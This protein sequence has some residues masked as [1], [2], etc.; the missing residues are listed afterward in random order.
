MLN[1]RK[2]SKISSNCSFILSDL[3]EVADEWQNELD[4]I[5]GNEPE[6]TSQTD[7]RQERVDRLTYAIGIITE[8]NEKFKQWIN[9]F[10]NINPNSNNA[11]ENYDNLK[12]DLSEI[13]DDYVSAQSN[14]NGIAQYINKLKKV[15]SSM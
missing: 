4:D 13:I 14:K 10:D 9:S 12:Y 1:I 11:E 6:Y 7:R 5:E 15:V 2:L 3:Q 8:T